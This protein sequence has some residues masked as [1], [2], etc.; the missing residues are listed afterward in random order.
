MKTTLVGPST[1][2]PP[3]PQVCLTP[4]SLPPAM[5]P[6]AT[7]HGSL[8]PRGSTLHPH[9]APTSHGPPSIQGTLSS[10]PPSQPR[11]R[12]GHLSPSL[13]PLQQIPAQALTSSALG[14][15]WSR[16][17]PPRDP[18]PQH[19]PAGSPT[20]LGPVGM[21]AGAQSGT[22]Q[23]GLT[24]GRVGRRGGPAH[25]DVRL[26]AL[27]EAQRGVAGA[28]GA[29]GHQ[30]LQLLQVE[31]EL[32]SP[33]RA[34]DRR[35]AA[36]GPGSGSGCSGHL[37]VGLLR[38]C[39]TCRSPPASGRAAHAASR[40]PRRRPVARALPAPQHPGCHHLHWELGVCVCVCRRGVRLEGGGGQPGG[41]TAW[42]RG[43]EQP[44]GGQ[45]Q[46]GGGVLVS[47]PQRSGASDRFT[48]PPRQVQVLTGHSGH[49][50][51]MSP[52]G[53]GRQKPPSPHLPP[54]PTPTPRLASWGWEELPSCRVCPISTQMR[55]VS[56]QNWSHRPQ[57]PRHCRSCSPGPG[58]AAHLAQCTS[59][60]PPA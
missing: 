48:P 12:E 52:P 22:G 16:P 8:V 11:T 15:P 29:Q 44:G 46:P 40:R 25:L 24:T 4:W 56:P 23:P 59:W 21:L 6:S 34:R 2:G 26:G 10:Q 50:R 47:C 53:P 49:H 30:L 57:A 20:T 7:P 43:R 27:Q 32:G 19:A 38:A 13:P 14:S 36:G 1:T 42:R 41:G 37:P 45:E 18:R 55:V 31:P 60:A 5:P 51:N 35:Q 3:N 9:W 17:P 33:E 28:V 39:P 54:P 58:T